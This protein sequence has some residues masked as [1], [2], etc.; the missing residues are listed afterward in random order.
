[1]R[2]H[3]AHHCF[4][5]CVYYNVTKVSFCCFLAGILRFV[6]GIDARPTPLSQ[7]EVDTLQDSFAGVA[8][9]NTAASERPQNLEAL[10]DFIVQKTPKAGFTFSTFLVGDGSQVAFH[11]WICKSYHEAPSWLSTE[12]SRP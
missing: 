3:A 1:M 2:A 9:K 12:L 4:I 10:I 8:L 6:L 11:Q 7:A 5:L